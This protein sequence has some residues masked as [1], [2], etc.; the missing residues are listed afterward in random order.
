KRFERSMPLVSCAPILYPRYRD[1]QD[2]S[3]AVTLTLNEFVERSLASIVLEALRQRS[4]L[5]QRHQPS[6]IFSF[7]NHLFDPDLR[8]DQTLSQPSIRKLQEAVQAWS[9]DLDESFSTPRPSLP[10]T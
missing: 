4:P 3:G 7:V 10:I 2:F 5:P 9:L 6:I 8:L 1:A